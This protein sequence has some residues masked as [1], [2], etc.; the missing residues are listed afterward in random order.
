MGCK[1]SDKPKP[2]HRKGLWSPEEDQR[3]RNYVLKYGHGC[4]SSVPINAG[5]QRN[6]K[7]CRLRWINY[8]R[9]GLKRGTFSTQEE[10]TILTLHRLLGNKWSQMAHHL[11]GRTD[12]EIKNYWHSY[13]K[14]KV[15]KAEGHGSNSTTP[16]SS[17]PNSHN[18]Q[19]LDSPIKAGMQI[20][21]YES[22]EFLEK[23][24][25]DLDQSIPQMFQSP[26]R[27]SFPK[28]M[29]AEWLSLDSFATTSEADACRGGLQENPSFGHSFVHGYPLDEDPFYHN[30]IS[31]VSASDVF[32]SQFKLH[33][34][35]TANEFIDFSSG[36]DVCSVF[37]MNSDIIYI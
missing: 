18:M 1:S 5:L 2:K 35:S 22:L 30:S 4:W 15:M 13:L 9:P 24:S 19:P 8:L 7:S 3:L 37:N 20:P 25:T 16:C 21:C 29:F 36:D 10:E 27:S 32:M 6:G 23:V 34:Q 28:I 11:P 12:N 31:E 14:K 26:N 17:S 33:D